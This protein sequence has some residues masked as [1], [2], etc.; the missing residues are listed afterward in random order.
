MEV[1]AVTYVLSFD[2]NHVTWHVSADC[3]SSLIL[4][5][6]GLILI[7]FPKPNEGNFN[8]EADCK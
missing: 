7:F 8:F 4:F 1:E 6:K 3:Q 5:K 2:F